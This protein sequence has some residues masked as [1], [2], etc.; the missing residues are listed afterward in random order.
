MEKIVIKIDKNQIYYLRFILEGY[1]N[2]FVLS[3]LDKNN[4]IVEIEYVPSKKELLSLILND[5]K[6]QIGLVDEVP[7]K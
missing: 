3:T 5:I 1:D 4:G 7:L 6:E 2:L